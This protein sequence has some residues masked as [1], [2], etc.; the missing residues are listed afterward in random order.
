MIMN[1]VDLSPLIKGL[2]PIIGIAISL[3]QYPKLEQWARAQAVESLAWKQGL[4]HIFH[5]EHRATGDLSHSRSDRT[6]L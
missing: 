4:P 2:L 5:P 1:I 6:R 3:G